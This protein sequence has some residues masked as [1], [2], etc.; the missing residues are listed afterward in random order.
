MEEAWPDRNRQRRRRHLPS[1]HLS[2]SPFQGCL[3]VACCG[4]SGLSGELGQ[5][6][7]STVFDARTPWVGAGLGGVSAWQQQPLTQSEPVRVRDRRRSKSKESKRTLRLR[8]GVNHLPMQHSH[9]QRLQLKMFNTYSLWCLLQGDHAPFRVAISS[10][11]SIGDL[12]EEI[13]KKVPGRFY[14]RDIILTKV[15]HVM[16]SM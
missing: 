15:R 7:L 14:A 9:E 4:R 10:A 11:L 16:I 1:P 2:P 3:I 8:T 5:S 13:F 12:K 6:I